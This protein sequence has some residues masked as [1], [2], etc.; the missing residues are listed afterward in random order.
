MHFRVGSRSPV[1]FRT[2][3]YVTTVNSSFQP[4]P[5]LVTKSSLL[6]AAKAYTEYYNMIHKNSKRYQGALT[7]TLKKYERLTFLDALKIHFQKFFALD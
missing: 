1:T 7:M 6:D 4:L 2:K 3:L 5:V